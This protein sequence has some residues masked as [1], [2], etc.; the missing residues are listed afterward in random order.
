MRHCVNKPGPVKPDL[1][2]LA[3]FNLSGF[4]SYQYSSLPKSS[5]L[6]RLAHLCFS[7]SLIPLTSD[8]V[9]KMAFV[10]SNL[11]EV[12]RSQILAGGR[13]AKKGF[14]YSRSVP[15]AA[16]P[17]ELQE[18]MAGTEAPETLTWKE[19]R[20]LNDCP[21]NQNWSVMHRSHIYWIQQGGAT[22]DLR[23]LL[24]R[25]RS[26]SRQTQHFSTGN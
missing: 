15:G 10:S 20:R 17:G 11:N 21:T 22:V 18:A 24:S 3:S 2:L 25:S 8:F 7:I 14:P 6:Q 19:K 13:I 16:T 12:M 9:C 26:C 4:L 1:F 23:L 5:T